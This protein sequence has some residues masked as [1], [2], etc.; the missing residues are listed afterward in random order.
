MDQ[1][2]ISDQQAQNIQQQLVEAF[3]IQDLP[4]DKQQEIL[5]RAGELILKRIFLKVMDSLSEEDK[6]Q[7]DSLLGKQSQPAQEEI[8]AFLGEKIPNINQLMQQ[9]IEAFKEEFKLA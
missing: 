3:G 5:S 6:N 2:Q 1:A 7:F 8:T 4:A 9:E